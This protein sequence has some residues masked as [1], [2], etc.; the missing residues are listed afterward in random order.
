M[1]WRELDRKLSALDE[2]EVKA[3]LD[4][5]MAGPRRTAIVERLHQRYASLR[6]TRERL[7][8]LKAIAAK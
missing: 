5:E 2:N 6:T 3:L 7:E 8:L 4:E 1:N